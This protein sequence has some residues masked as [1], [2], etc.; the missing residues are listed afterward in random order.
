M[1]KLLIAAMFCGFVLSAQPAQA[2][3][4]GDIKDGAVWLWNIVPSA[5]KI[6]NNGVHFVGETVHTGVHKVAELLTIDIGD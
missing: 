6:V 3:I 2:N 1:K 5:L 4:G